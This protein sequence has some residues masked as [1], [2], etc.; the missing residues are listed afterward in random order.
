MIELNCRHF[1]HQTK[2]S[3]GRLK[4]LVSTQY[5]TH[6]VN[7]GSKCANTTNQD[8][9]VFGVSFIVVF[10][11]RSLG[12]RQ[13][14]HR[15]WFV[16]EVTIGFG[17]YGRLEYNWKTIN[18]ECFDLVRR[19]PHSVSHELCRDKTYSV[20]YLPRVTVLK[21]WLVLT[22]GF[23]QLWEYSRHDE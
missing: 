2:L 9:I 10:L 6:N 22:V 19:R 23:S 18:C 14:V 17:P 13:I 8:E 16:W 15:Q 5:Y 3:Q 20:V 21:Q 12:Y 7:C 1:D 4:Y 11:P